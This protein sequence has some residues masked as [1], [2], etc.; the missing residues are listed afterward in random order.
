MYYDQSYDV[1]RRIKNI[2]DLR[3]DRTKAHTN[4]PQI[5]AH[6]VRIAHNDLVAELIYQ[7]NS[8]E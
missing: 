3:T 1:D 4:L 8:Y 5:T 6:R 2:S 7:N